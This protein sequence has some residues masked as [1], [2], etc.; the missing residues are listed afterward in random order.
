MALLSLTRIV[1]R[2]P[3]SMSCRALGRR[4]V[5]EELEEGQMK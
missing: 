5:G 1:V 4:E 3:R 2:L